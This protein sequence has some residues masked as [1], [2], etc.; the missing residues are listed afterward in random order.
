MGGKDRLQRG[1]RKFWGVMDSYL[2]S[3]DG[4][5]SQCGS[6]DRP[7]HSEHGESGASIIIQAYRSMS[8]SVRLLVSTLNFIQTLNSCRKRMKITFGYSLYQKSRR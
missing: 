8:C 3:G 4:L 1:M 5:T 6:E 7:E 2:D